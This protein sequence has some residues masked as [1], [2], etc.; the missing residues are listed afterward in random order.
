MNKHPI[1]YSDQIVVVENT[2]N[3]N[4]I[5]WRD[6]IYERVVS[7][8]DTSVITDIYEHTKK[9]NESKV[10]KMKTAL[11]ITSI[12]LITLVSTLIVLQV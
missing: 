12:L 7:V 3:K 10:R 6:G 11:W 9:R 1:V 5:I 8:V 2:D 4:T